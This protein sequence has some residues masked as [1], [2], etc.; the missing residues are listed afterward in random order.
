MAPPDVRSR[1][2]LYLSLL[3]MCLLWAFLPHGEGAF[4]DFWIDAALH[5]HTSLGAISKDAFFTFADGDPA[6]LG[7]ETGPMPWFADPTLKLALWRPLSVLSHRFDHATFGF[8]SFGA[9]V[10]SLAWALVLVLGAFRLFS[11]TLS[12]RAASFALVVFALASSH[13]EPLIWLSARNALVA[14]AFGIWTLTLYVESREGKGKGRARLALLCFV[15]ALLSGE[16]ALGILPYLAACELF[17]PHKPWAERARA[18]SPFLVTALIW[19]IAYAAQGYGTS[20][21][22]YYLNPLSEPLGFLRELPG[23]LAI[24][25]GGAVL[26]APTILWF[27]KPEL[28]ALLVLA[29]VLGFLILLFACLPDLQKGP[30]QPRATLAWLGLGA[31]VSL[32][33]PA[34]GMLGA[35]SLIVASIGVS[36]WVGSALGSTVVIDSAPWRRTK[37]GLVAVLALVHL[38]LSPLTW[39]ITGKTYRDAF[40]AEKTAIGR[41]ELSDLKGKRIFLLFAP[42]PAFS[43]YLPSRLTVQGAGFDG[44]HALSLA[45]VAHR[46]T[47]VAE[48][49]FVLAQ[50]EP[51]PPSFEQAFRGAQHPLQK[52]EVIDLG[53]MRATAVDVEGAFRKQVSFRLQRSLD[54]AGYVFLAYRDGALRKVRPPA[55]GESLDI[56]FEKGPW[57]F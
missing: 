4:D 17:S 11:L 20:G 52:G 6:H 50:R 16:A 40:A 44:F 23:R 27:V 1:R 9:S 3:L 24:L 57:T 37:H 34:A 26:G 19:L 39:L 15:L 46:M 10:H 31:L 7:R 41:S 28:R 2:S 49:E 55:I 35:R 32:V 18:L 56:A 8:I 36:A 22:G 25:V 33:P 53:F 45:P 54:D 48:D 29:G 21:S 47:R 13:S 12:P 51:P 5:D 30:R 43:I 38:V 14:A 42:D